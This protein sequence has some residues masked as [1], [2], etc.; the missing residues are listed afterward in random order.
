MVTIVQG[1]DN[2]RQSAKPYC[3]SQSR[4]DKKKN[5]AKKGPFADL[6]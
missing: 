5:I 3:P 1:Y 6:F 2:Y 4:T